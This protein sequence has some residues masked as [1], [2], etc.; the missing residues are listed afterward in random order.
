MYKKNETSEVFQNLSSSKFFKKTLLFITVAITVAAMF[1]SSNI[2]AQNTRNN[3]QVNS[4]NN[5]T[6]IK[7]KNTDNVD[8]N[9]DDSRKMPKFYWGVYGLGLNLNMHFANFSKVSIDCPTCVSKD[10]GNYGFNSGLK[11][12][13]GGLFEYPLYDKI[14]GQVVKP[15]DNIAPMSVG[16]RLGYSNF[17]ADFS[18]EA[19]VG[20]VIGPG[21]VSTKGTSK[22]IL[23]NKISAINLSPYFSYKLADG[24]VSNIGV[25]FNLLTKNIFTQ[26][27]TLVSPPNASFS[28]GQKSRNDWTDQEIPNVNKLIAGLS[29]GF[30]Y[31]VPLN[32]K[33]TIF[34]VPELK[35]NFNFINVA[36]DLNW[37]ISALQVGFAFKFPYFEGEEK[38]I[39]NTIYRRDTI[40][41]YKKGITAPEIVLAN[42]TK[43]IVAGGYDTIITEKYIRYLPQ[44]FDLTA[45]LKYYGIDDKNR[46]I[47]VPTVIIEEFESQESSPILPIIYF[48]DGNADLSQTKMKLL[49]VNETRHFS[50]LHLKSDLFEIY[51]HT[52]NIIGKRLKENPRAQIRIVG[53]SSGFGLDKQNDDVIWQKRAN[54]VK[55]Y[56]VNVWKIEE[57]QFKKI[58]RGEP[59]KRE[60]GSRSFEDV[61]IENQKVQIFTDDLPLLKPV[62]LS[63]IE[64]I[65]NPPQIGFEIAANSGNGLENYALTL[66]QGSKE[67]RNF[68]SNS[69]N[70]EKLNQVI[71]WDIGVEPI[72]ELEE[73]VDAVFVVKDK[74]KQTKTVSDKINI[75]Q[76]TIKHKRELIIDDIKIDR[77]SLVL[78]DIDKANIT[79]LQNEILKDI[80]KNI[81]PNS[82]LF[83]TGHADR[84]GDMIYNE[85]LARR[86]CEEVN[87]IINP[88]SKINATLE[89]IGSSKLLYDNS[90]PEGRA[91]SRTVR[92]EI[93]TPIK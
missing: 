47:D 3:N 23:E 8:I 61:V 82:K 62:T 48:P 43:N 44:T 89:A 71:T 9:A 45:S 53:Y 4:R 6:T 35:Y 49:T 60:E 24:F 73:A 28:D 85:N 59:E 67:I 92:V 21:G 46:R 79:P 66:S 86:R 72:P 93:H 56:F 26:N 54:T 51:Y 32:S 74:Q 91:F 65:S 78:F 29:L 90:S 10:H 75:K 19:D 31:H 70:S 18:V 55:D 39:P 16:V 27:E 20:N 14:N 2:N 80:K 7:Q 42:S 63:E 25:N 13:F 5:N 83:I 64:K 58:E 15:A 37:K 87:K 57:K 11:F 81:K 1:S 88:D 50:E 68:S 17:D 12:A 34:L 38:I 84:T 69:L 77:Y 30:E 76:R 52:L 40:I 36:S 41:E 33:K 22:H